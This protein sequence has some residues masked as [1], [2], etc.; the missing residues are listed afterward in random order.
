MRCPMFVPSLSWQNDRFQYQKTTAFKRD[1]FFRTKGLF[2]NAQ[3]LRAMRHETC[4]YIYERLRSVFRVLSLC[5]SRAWLGNMIISSNE[6]WGKTAIFLPRIA[7][8]SDVMFIRMY[9][10]A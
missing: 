9:L 2:D 10:R 8:A 1:A 3:R 5:L 4:V 7:S 6:K